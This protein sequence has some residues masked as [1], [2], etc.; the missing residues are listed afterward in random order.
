MTVTAQPT[1]RSLPPIC[2][3][4]RHTR[5]QPCLRHHRFQQRRLL[6]TQSFPATSAGISRATSWA[7]RRTQG[8]ADTLW[9][10]EGTATYGGILAGTVAA[11]GFYRH[12]GTTHEQEAEP[13]RGKI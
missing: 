10:I 8:A 12:R 7:A 1:R 9:V 3:G 4:C 13:W 11:H 5:T 6:D 2:R